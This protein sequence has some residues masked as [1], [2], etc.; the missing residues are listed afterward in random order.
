MVPSFTGRAALSRWPQPTSSWWVSS[1]I[2]RIRNNHHRQNS[3]LKQI[4][5]LTQK[6]FKSLHP[7]L[8]GVGTQAEHRTWG[9][10]HYEIFH[11]GNKC[12]QD[13]SVNA[14]YTPYSTLKIALV[15]F[16]VLWARSRLYIAKQPPPIIHC[17]KLLEQSSR[18]HS[19]FEISQKL[20][21][22]QKCWEG[23][24]NS[25]LKL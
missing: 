18:N 7:Y 1:H 24:Y 10:L 9:A 20:Q 17:K 8:R 12:F 22:F 15:M 13:Y 6:H 11:S 19:L 14:M 5:R 25:L 4:H 21:Q 3:G 2:Q 16:L 23:F